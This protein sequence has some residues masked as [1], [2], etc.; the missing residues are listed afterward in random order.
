MRPERRKRGNRRGTIGQA[1]HQSG[2][3]AQHLGRSRGGFTTK[4]RPVVDGRGMPLVLQVTAGNIN[5]SVLFEQVIE[6][7]RSRVAIRSR[8]CLI[9]SGAMRY[10][11]WPD[12]EALAPGRVT[13]PARGSLG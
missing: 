11:V 12:R 2:Q 7:G 6:G 5:D 1:D 10:A 13:Q 8:T 9:T 3:S 4:V